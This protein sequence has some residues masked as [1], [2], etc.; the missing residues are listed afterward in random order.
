MKEE[1][2][3]TEAEWCSISEPGGG[4]PADDASGSSSKCA[5]STR[6]HFRSFRLCVCASEA[7]PRLLWLLLFNV[8]KAPTNQEAGD[9]GEDVGEE[10]EGFSSPP[11]S[12]Q[13]MQE[14]WKENLQYQE[15]IMHAHRTAPEV[16]ISRS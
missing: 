8:P 13:K 7:P 9:D 15:N 6:F 3:E 5:M 4:T 16:M 11:R 2:I 12:V 10:G 14:D 1:T